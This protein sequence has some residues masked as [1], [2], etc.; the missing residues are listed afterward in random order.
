MSAQEP[1]H[2]REAGMITLGVD[3]HKQVHVAVA[4]DEAGR[5][6]DR[7][8]GPNSPD[9]WE[10]L[11]VWAVLFGD[12][13]QWG[14]E[15]AWNY[16]RGLAQQLVA[17]GET[18]YEVN[19][20]WTAAGRRRARRPG[21]T[22]RQDAQ[23]VAL[24]VRQEAPNL[25]RV[26]A[27]DVTAILDLLTTQREAAVGESTRLRNQ[28]HALLLQID[29][30]Y[31]DRL[32]NLETQTALAA[33]ASYQAPTKT[34][35]QEQRATIVR[36]LAQRLRLAMNQAAELKRQIETY[37]E[38]AG[39]T[40]LTTI[41]GVGLILAGTLAGILGPGLRFTTDAELA[42]YAGAAPLEASSAGLVRHR[43]NRGGNRRLNAV[44]HMI[45]LTQ[46]RDWEPARKYVAKRL[47]EGKTKREAM[48][49]LKRYLVRAIWNAWKKCLAPSAE[50]PAVEA[51]GT[52]Q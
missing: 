43:L 5:E 4:L 50:E 45:A 9:G 18:V 26:A 29:P 6:I 25:P 35:L 32:P 23:A 49:A 41:R 44:L 13:R 42:A 20:R 21:K 36:Q 14:I 10:S 16:G 38:T 28:I 37:T 34:P 12:E 11:R 27:D 30:Q 15:G 47:S 40:A 1:F 24:F 22:D 46:I 33:L 39:F 19:A 31:K 17:A 8:R 7:W 48:R 2:Y 51:S 52:P 3:A